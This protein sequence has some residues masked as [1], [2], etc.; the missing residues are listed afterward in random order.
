MA[1]LNV[2]ASWQSRQGSNRECDEAL[3]ACRIFA[4][5]VHCHQHF[6]T[7]GDTRRRGPKGPLLFGPCA[8][9]ALGRRASCCLKCKSN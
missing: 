3:S 7:V 8:R 5:G 4:D 6:L 1:Q 9:S 2:S